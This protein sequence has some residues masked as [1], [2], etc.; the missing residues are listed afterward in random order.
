MQGPDRTICISQE[1]EIFL[2]DFQSQIIRTKIVL[3][4]LVKCFALTSNSSFVIIADD[5]NSLHFVHVHTKRVLYSQTFDSA[6]TNIFIYR[7]KHQNVD[8]LVV[9][10]KDQLVISQNI[11][12][13]GLNEAILSKD[14]NL[15]MK[16]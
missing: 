1:N 2:V 14:F 9:L 3:D 11:D 13:D 16:V 6:V 10:N 12:V 8:E 15:V 4:G 7:N 5:E